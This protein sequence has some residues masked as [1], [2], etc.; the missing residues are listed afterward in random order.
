MATADVQQPS[1]NSKVSRIAIR[2]SYRGKPG[3]AMIARIWVM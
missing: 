3:E 1:R 2:P